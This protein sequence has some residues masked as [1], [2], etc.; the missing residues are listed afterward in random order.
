MA[1]V[2]GRW[3]SRATEKGLWGQGTGKEQRYL[4][5]DQWTW[6]WDYWNF[7]SQFGL[8]RLKNLCLICLFSFSS[9]SFPTSREWESSFLPWR[10]HTVLSFSRPRYLF[11]KRKKEAFLLQMPREGLSSFHIPESSERSHLVYWLV[12]VTLPPPCNMSFK[13]EAFP[14]Q[15]WIN[16]LWQSNWMPPLDK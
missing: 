5:K 6:G 7:K 11:C 3:R 12:A 10:K 2:Y 8:L 4:S 13:W 16:L 1:V 15:Y 9:F 14:G